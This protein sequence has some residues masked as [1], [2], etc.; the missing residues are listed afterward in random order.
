M[1]KNKSNADTDEFMGFGSQRELLAATIYNVR[2]Q[3]S[4]EMTPE[5]WAGIKERFPTSARV[6]LEQADE[7]M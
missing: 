4:R 6:C 1:D 5:R 7:E 2:A 3:S